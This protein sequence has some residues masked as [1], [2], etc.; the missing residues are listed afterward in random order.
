M[1]LTTLLCMHCFS[2]SMSFSPLSHDLVSSPDAGP[3]KRF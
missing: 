1:L 3:S 2:A